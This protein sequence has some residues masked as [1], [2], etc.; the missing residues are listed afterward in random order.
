MTLEVSAFHRLL[1]QTPELRREIEEGAMQRL[2]QEPVTAG[3]DIA[4]AEL[5][6]AP[7]D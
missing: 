6:D 3:G 1:E 5:E 2:V 4:A 7:P